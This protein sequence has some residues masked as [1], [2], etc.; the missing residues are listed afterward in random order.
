MTSFVQCVADDGNLPVHHARRGHYVDAGLGL[1]NGQAR[2][3]LVSFVVVDVAVLIEHAA[4]AMI[5]EFVQ[6]G[7]S[8]HDE[9]V[10]YFGDHFPN[11]HVEDAVRVD[12]GGTT[13]VERCWYPEQHDASDA[14][15]EIGRASCRQRGWTEGG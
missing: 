12:A 5:G 8:H 3:D 9:I 4:V 10:A 15:L 7:I 2:I 13:S 14:G 1:S 11:G 6:A